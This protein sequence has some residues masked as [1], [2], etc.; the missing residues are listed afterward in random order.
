VGLPVELLTGKLP[1]YQRHHHSLMLWRCAMEAPTPNKER[2]FQPEHRHPEP[3]L[4]NGAF[5][6]LERLAL[7]QLSLVTKDR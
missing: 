1:E 7:Q 2:L 6:A 4:Q 3:E 5:L